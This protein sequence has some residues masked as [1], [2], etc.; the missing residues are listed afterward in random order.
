MIRLALT[1][2]ATTLFFPPAAPRAQQARPN[3]SGTWTMDQSRSESPHYPD[4]VG[5]VTLVIT[6][7]PTEM[8]IETRRG[9]KTSTV[10]YRVYDSENAPVGTTGNAA[11]KSYWN[12]MTLVADG[13]RNVQDATVRT[14]EIRS[15]DSTGEEMTVETTLIVEHG[16]TLAG[17]KNYGTGKDVF[18]KS[19]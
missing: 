4:F 1:L 8:T 17:T 16:Y 10:T 9:E 18:R 11:S 13:V 7:T 14:R 5:P 15:L 2:I 6:H 3:F 12:G 19:R